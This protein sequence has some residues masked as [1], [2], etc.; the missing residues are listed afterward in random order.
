MGS[1]VLALCSV[2][3]EITRNEWIVEG[4]DGVVTLGN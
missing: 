4:G 3:E 1:L 2:R